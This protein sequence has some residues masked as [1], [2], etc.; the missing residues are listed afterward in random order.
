LPSYDCNGAM[1]WRRAVILAEAVENATGATKCSLRR[2][3][4]TNT[5]SMTGTP[6]GTVFTSATFREASGIDHSAASK[7][8]SQ[9]LK[10][11]TI[12]SPA[13][14]A[15]VGAG[16]II[17]V[18]E[19]IGRGECRGEAHGHDQ[20]QQAGGRGESAALRRR[21]GR[22]RARAKSPLRNIAQARCM[23]VPKMAVPGIR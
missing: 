21:N 9:G 19:A 13:I 20:R 4:K 16:T 17:V 11:R 2:N 23:E 22:A 3:I 7:V 10:P 18:I 12:S 6:S 1:S 5:A 8:F 14:K 15:M